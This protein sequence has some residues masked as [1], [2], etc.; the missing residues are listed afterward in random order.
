MQPHHLIYC[1]SRH[2]TLNSSVQPDDSKSGTQ[3]A[4]DTLSGNK[5]QATSGGTGGGIIDK[6][7]DTLGMQK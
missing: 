6:A 1:V 3:K 5:D 2:L 4:G 7:K